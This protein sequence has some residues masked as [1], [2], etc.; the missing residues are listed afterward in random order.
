MIG[1]LLAIFSTSMKLLLRRKAPATLIVLVALAGPL[2]S[3]FLFTSDGSL[4]GVLRMVLTYN[5][6][7]TSTAL[8]LLTLYLATTVLDSE[9]TE[10]QMTLTASKPVAR[11]QI[12]FGKW[13]AVAAI[14]GGALALAGV[15]G[16]LSLKAR[17][18]APQV[19]QLRKILPQTQNFTQAQREEDAQEQLAQT[20]S[21][22]LVSRRPFRPEIP[23]V[24]DELTK[25]LTELRAQN[26]PAD[27]MPPA[28][29]VRRALQRARKKQAFPIPYGTGREYEFKN[30]PLTSQPV[31]VRYQLN[32][33]TDP[34]QL[35]WLQ[36]R[37]I[38]AGPQGK[39]P[40]ESQTNS[41]TGATREFRIPGQMIAPDGRLQAAIVNDLPM[42]TRGEPQNL[43]VP[44]LNGFNLMIPQ[45]SFEANYLRG[46]LLLWV[47]LLMLAAVGVGATAFLSGSVSAFLLFSLI[48]MGSISSFVASSVLPSEAMALMR[49]PEL[50]FDK[51][52]ALFLLR[53]LPDFDLTSP[54]TALAGGT[55]ISWWFLLRQT[56][57][58]LLIRGGIFFGI[59]ML[60]FSRR[61][62]GIPR[63]FR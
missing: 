33:T 20:R 10:D 34:G 24:E 41:R 37:W 6:Y 12:L 17:C 49:E 11:W 48:V 31:T 43:E 16:Y 14:T 3:Y 19:V 7:L 58:D 25:I 63:I 45:G 28:D 4:P 15:A 42:Q 39:A 50:S 38:F 51:Y 40:Y 52:V 60:A 57:A 9:L 29:E 23:T 56:V 8:M 32:G 2:S 35:G 36:A 55:E 5:Y 1:T 18:T 53:L 30:L 62:L 59:G 61:E 47:R 27:K 26:L 44:L 22:L 21:E 46:Q 13:L 54:L